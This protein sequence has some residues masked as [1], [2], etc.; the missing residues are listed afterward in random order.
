MTRNHTLA[1]LFLG[2]LAAC[3][4][5]DSGP[6]EEQLRERE[7]AAREACIAERLLQQSRDELATLE[8]LAVVAGPVAFQRAYVQHAELRLAAMAHHDSAVNRSATPED[9]SRHEE[10]AAA[11]QISAPDPESVEAN[12]IRSYEAKAA[13]I[14]NDPNHPCNW[15]AEL[16]TE[17]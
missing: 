14:F 3:A 17:E 12:V 2:A 13:A 1:L 8:S 15:Q 7:L 10:A 5:D 11:I 6:T 9:S 4:P 16:D